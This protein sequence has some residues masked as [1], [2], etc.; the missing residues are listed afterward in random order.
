[1]GFLGEA[2][3]LQFRAEVFNA[4]NRANFGV[5]NSETF[6]GAGASVAQAPFDVAGQITNTAGENRQIQLSLRMQF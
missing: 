3:K 2:G 5:P 6:A 4:L 1:M